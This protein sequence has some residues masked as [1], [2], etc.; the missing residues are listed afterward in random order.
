M[1]KGQVIPIPGP[2]QGSFRQALR[3]PAARQWGQASELREPRCSN[4][5]VRFAPTVAE[6]ANVRRAPPV[7]LQPGT[8]LYDTDAW[9]LVWQEEF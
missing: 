1:L 5:P 3:I 6:G 4:P 9:E 2:R 7:H 8:F